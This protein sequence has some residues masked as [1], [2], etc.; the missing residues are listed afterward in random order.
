MTT[1]T[2]EPITT[3]IEH[4]DFQP[5]CEMD[6]CDRLATHL[7]V[8]LHKTCF[9]DCFLCTSCVEALERAWLA[10]ARIRREVPCPRCRVRLPNDQLVFRFEPLL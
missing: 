7:A 6:G 8:S 9:R 1:T 4:L 3:T 5:A 10:V 2:L